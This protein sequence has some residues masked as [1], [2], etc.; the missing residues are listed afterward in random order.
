MLKNK[1]FLMGITFFLFIFIG[2]FIY[3]NILESYKVSPIIKKDK[4]KIGILE[5][6]EAIDKNIEQGLIEALKI[7]GYKKDKNLNIEIVKCTGIDEEQKRQVRKMIKSDKDLIV[8]IGSDATRQVAFQNSK[9][10][11]VV[12]GV[13]EIFQKKY[14]KNKYNLTGV[15]KNSLIIQEINDV[16]KIIHLK[17][18]GVVCNINNQNSNDQFNYLQDKSLVPLIKIEAL[19]SRNLLKQIKSLKSKVDAVYIPEEDVYISDIDE[20][21]KVLNKEK[22]PIIS[23]GALMVEKGALLS[24]VIENYRMGFDAGIIASRLFNENIVPCE[25]PFKIENDP[26][27]IINMVE[28]KKL[29]LNVPTEIW[30]KAR[31]MYLYENISGK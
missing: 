13:P 31:K 19:N 23:D 30:Q 29:N 5:S 1:Y 24:V 8:S 21:V 2:F 18:L 7:N 9:I 20:I 28:V 26:D 14:F 12:I 17:K 11:V 6:N 15:F 3:C 16:N 22:I 10:P 25:I 4:Y 27:I